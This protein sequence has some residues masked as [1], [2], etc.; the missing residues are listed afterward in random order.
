MS[1]LPPK[2]GHSAMSAMDQKQTS[3]STP[4]VSAPICAPAAVFK[5]PIHLA[6]R[7]PRSHMT[8]SGGSDKSIDGRGESSDHRR[9][10]RDWPWDCEGR[11]RSG[12]FSSLRR[13]RHKRVRKRQIQRPSGYQVN[14]KVKLLRFT[15]GNVPRFCALEN[16]I[17]HRR[18]ATKQCREVGAITNN[19]TGIGD[20]SKWRDYRN[21]MLN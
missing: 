2:A 4:R 10:Q 19:T 12:A 13:S 16:S 7:L 21:P 11:P 1:A 3:G 14:R 18:G 20:F 8:M 9:Q 6:M 15:D 17:D 5:T